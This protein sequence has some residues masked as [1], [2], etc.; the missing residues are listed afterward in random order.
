MLCGYFVFV[1]LCVH[2]QNISKNIYLMKFILGRSIPSDPLTK[3]LYF[4]PRDKGGCAGV[5]GGRR[6]RVGVRGGGAENM[7][8]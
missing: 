4:Q 8:Q 6:V 7:A 2:D 3:L 1:C 5:G